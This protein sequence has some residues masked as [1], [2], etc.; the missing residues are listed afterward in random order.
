MDEPFGALDPIARRALQQEFLAWKRAARKGRAARDPRPRARR[1]GWRTGSRSCDR[2]RARPGRHAARDRRRARPTTS[3]GSSCRSERARHGYFWERRSEI[4]A[5]TGEHLLLVLV[6]DRRWPSS[7]GV[8]LGVALTRR[9][10]LARPGPRTRRRRADDP[11]PRALRVPDSAAAS[12]AGSG[13]APRSSRSSST[14]CFRSCATPTPGSVRSTRRSSRRPTGLGMT[15]RQRLWWVELPLSLP[16]VL[17]GV[18]IATV[19]SIGHRDDR[20]GDRRG[21]AGRPDLPRHRD[22]RQ[23]VD[24]RGR[25]ARRRC[26][27]LAADGAARLR[28][29]GAGPESS[30]AREDAPDGAT[31]SPESARTLAAALLPLLRRRSPRRRLRGERARSGSGRRTSPSR[32]CSARSIAQA[33][34]ARGVA[35]RPEAQPRAARS[36]A[37]RRSSRASSISTRSTRARRSPRSWRRSRTRDPAAVRDEVAARVRAA[38]GP[39]LVAAARVREHVRARRAGRRRA[40]LGP[41][42]DLGPR[43]ARRGPA[44]RA[45]ATSSWSARTGTRVSPAPTASRSGSGPSRW[46]S[47]CSIRR[48]RAGSVDVIAGNSTDGLIAAIGGVVLE[49]DRRYF[50]PYE[51]AFVVRGAVWRARPEV[52]AVAAS[53]SPARS[54]RRRCADGTPSSTGTSGARKTSRKRCSRRSWSARR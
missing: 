48:S 46:T 3:S 39:R 23:P 38:L 41:P 28:R 40:R 30:A 43:G 31:G 50:P 7:I 19:V 20:R 4:L 18:R 6:V 8:P 54:T 22:R 49:D 27:A 15:P 25:A 13:R 34:E 29:S 33:L 1:S 17:G 47:A 44:A 26:L 52:G 9:P 42:D 16:V 24:P 11:E 12:S 51:A 2:G 45:S 10:R 37:T 5:L 32:S 53:P 14:R 36:S 21:R 35:R